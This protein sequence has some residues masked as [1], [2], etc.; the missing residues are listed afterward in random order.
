MR[1]RA[2]GPWGDSNFNLSRG[3]PVYIF[4]MPRSSV[5]SPFTEDGWILVCNSMIADRKSVVTIENGFGEKLVLKTANIIAME[6]LFNAKIEKGWVLGPDQL[7]K[8]GN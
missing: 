1:G 4:S 7:A 2:L 6:Q 8:S 3:L 5:P